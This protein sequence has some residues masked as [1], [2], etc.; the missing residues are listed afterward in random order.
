MCGLGVDICRCLAC[1]ASQCP[2]LPPERSPGMC[3]VLGS[4]LCVKACCFYCSWRQQLLLAL[5]AGGE[6]GESGPLAWFVFQFEFFQVGQGLSSCHRFHHPLLQ[7]RSLENIRHCLFFL[8]VLLR[9]NSHSIQFIIQFDGFLYVQSLCHINFR[10]LSSPHKESL[11]PFNSHLLTPLAPL[12]PQA[13][14]NP[15]SI[16]IEY[17]SARLFV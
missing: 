17:A 8:A 2:L 9:Y 12:Q 5:L 6:T 1:R 14:I 16:S 7:P 15:L 4:V 10:V 3:Q 11:Y 13:I